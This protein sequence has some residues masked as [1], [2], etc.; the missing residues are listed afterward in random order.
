MNSYII[1]DTI[2][3]VDMTLKRN[4]KDLMGIRYALAPGK[5]IVT[6]RIRNTVLP[7]DMGM[8][9]TLMWEQITLGSQHYLGT[10]SEVQP[11]YHPF[12]IQA[13]CVRW[14]F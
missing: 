3:G 1:T 12:I 8:K 2:K 6:L 11:F 9:D 14:V 5:S 4:M 10:C 13:I 7:N